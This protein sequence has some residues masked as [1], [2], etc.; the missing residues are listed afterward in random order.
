MCGAKHFLSY[1]AAATET[2]DMFLVVNPSHISTAHCIT[3]H[4]TV[5]CITDGTDTGLHILY[6]LPVTYTL[7]VH[8]STTYNHNGNVI[9][10]TSE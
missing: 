3:D 4:K 10:K 5:M 7:Q 1:I 6:F 8:S 2:K 9:F